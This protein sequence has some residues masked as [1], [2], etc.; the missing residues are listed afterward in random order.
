[1]CGLAGIFPRRQWSAARLHEV[2]ERMSAAIAHRGPDDSGIWVDA[3]VG[4]ALGFRRLAIVDLSPLGHQPMQS[5][6]GR[7]TMIFNGEVYNY[8]ALRR[9][10]EGF[11]CRFRGHSDTEI[12]LAAFEQWGI[13]AAGRRLIGMLAYAALEGG[14]RQRTL[15]GFRL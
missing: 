4:I 1:M 5:A 15:V 14:R 7:F 13:E 6:G 12:I 8:R 9:E 2:T 10:L 3:A 11:G